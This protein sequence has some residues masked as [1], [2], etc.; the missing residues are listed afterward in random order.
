[1]VWVLLLIVGLSFSMLRSFFNSVCIFK[2]VTWGQIATWRAP[3]MRSWI[4]AALFVWLCSQVLD[5]G[6]IMMPPALEICAWNHVLDA[7][8]ALGAELASRFYSGAHGH[9]TLPQRAVG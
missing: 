4:S 1:M 9:H 5:L 8:D 7:V 2:L 3:E 6:K